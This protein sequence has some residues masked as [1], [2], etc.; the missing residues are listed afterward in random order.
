MVV[1]AVVSVAQMIVLDANTKPYG[2]VVS[3]MTRVPTVDADATVVVNWPNVLMPAPRL[4][5]FDPS[6]MYKDD[7][8]A[9]RDPIQV[10][11][12]PFDPRQPVAY[13]A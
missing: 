5:V 12:L 8:Y 9:T 6:E 1:S 11:T 3:A 7:E 13:V 2:W 4:P 10:Y